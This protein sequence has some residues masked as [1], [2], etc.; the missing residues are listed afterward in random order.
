[1][2]ADYNGGLAV[3]NKTQYAALRKKRTLND[4]DYEVN[5]GLGKPTYG[6]SVAFEV[7]DSSGVLNRLDICKDGNLY[8][9]TSKYKVYD[10]HNW[11]QAFAGIAGRDANATTS[12][13]YK[14][15]YKFCTL[16]CMPNDWRR[17][18]AIFLFHSEDV[19]YRPTFFYVSYR[20][21]QTTN[22]NINAL[23]NYWLS[24]GSTTIPDT[25]ITN[26]IFFAANKPTS[27]S[28]DNCV[29]LYWYQDAGYNALR[30]YL[31]QGSNREASKYFSTDYIDL[32]VPTK[33]TLTDLSS[34][35]SLVWKATDVLN[36]S[37][38]TMFTS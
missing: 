16:R 35:Y 9:Q 4:V 7:S 6:A 24:F 28:V 21:N 32:Y 1:M 18:S 11:G 34:T 20:F 30:Y 36:T 14:G 15:Y 19:V 10:E 23:T 27:S 8:T 3:N 17:T 13:T 2:G 22:A 25:N 38:K 26:R 12:T 31:I 29:D 33:P 5:V 37:S